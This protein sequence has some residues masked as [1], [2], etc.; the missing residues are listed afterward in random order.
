MLLIP[1]IFGT[2]SVHV[3]QINQGT[4]MAELIKSGNV[5][6]TLDK[7]VT[8]SIDFLWKLF[9]GVL[10]F[11]VGKFIISK[12]NGLAGKIMMKRKI[13]GTLQGFLHSALLTLLYVILLINIIN[14]VGTQTVSIAALIASAGLAI[15]LAVKDNLANFAGGVMIL[16]NKPFRGGDYIEAQN[17]AG[18][19]QSIGILYTTLSTFDNKTIY[20]PN[21]PLS[22]GNIINYNS[23]SGTRRS[24]IV[25]SVDYGSDVEEVKELLLTI[26]RNHP[27]VLKDPE[28]FARMTKMNDSSIDFAFR[29]WARIEDFWEVTWDLN[30]TVYKTLNEKGLNI[31]FPQMTVHLARPDKK[32]AE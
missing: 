25:V 28:P 23:I 11:V 12:I 2:D 15:G 18:T 6:D 3:P 26:A 1:S 21:G 5:E 29:V 8:W 22:T 17:M 32:T 10:L 16:L 19:V 24:E 9:L 27:K 20:V 7:A 30:E 14:I 31:P 4:T 13:D